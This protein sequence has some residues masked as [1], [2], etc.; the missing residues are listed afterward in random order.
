LEAP[1]GE[2]QGES[3]VLCPLV[4]ETLSELRLHTIPD[5]GRGFA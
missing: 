5:A 1:I 2:E 3:A 4:E